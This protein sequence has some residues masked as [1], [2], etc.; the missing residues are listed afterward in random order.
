MSK[1]IKTESPFNTGDFVAS[2]FYACMNCNNDGDN[3]TTE[4]AYIDET[5]GKLP[6]CSKCG[7]SQWYKI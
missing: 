7:H 5:G 3:S 1:I 4:S 6:S 2:G